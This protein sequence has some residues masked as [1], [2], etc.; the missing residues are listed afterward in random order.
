MW[1]PAPETHPTEVMLAVLVLAN[2]IR[3]RK[4]VK[5]HEGGQS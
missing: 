1:L 3:K 2:L 4:L 5:H